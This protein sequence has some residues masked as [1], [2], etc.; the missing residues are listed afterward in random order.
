MFQRDFLEAHVTFP[1]GN[2]FYIPLLADDTGWPVKRSAYTWLRLRAEVPLSA[3][4]PGVNRL[5]APFLQAHLPL[6]GWHGQNALAVLLYQSSLSHS[7][8]HDK[9]DQKLV[10]PAGV[11]PVGVA[12]QKHDDQNHRVR[13]VPELHREPT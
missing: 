1:G 11:Q 3:L 8:L 6:S 4:V 9:P 10:V 2:E 5:F 12:P 13:K 7:G